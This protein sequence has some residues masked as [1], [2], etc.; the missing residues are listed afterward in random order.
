MKKDVIFCIE[1]GEKVS[2]SITSDRVEITIRGIKFS[3]VEL[4]AYCVKC[5]KEIYVPEVNDMNVV[6]REEAY[7]KAAGLISVSDIQNI[8]TKYNIGAGPL[9]KLLGFGEITINRYISGQLP[10]RDHS[11]K[12]LKLRFDRNMMKRILEEGKEKI[13]NVAYEKCNR[14]LEQLDYLYGQNKIDLVARYFLTKSGDITPLALQKLLYYA[15]SF[16]YALFKENLFEDDCQ[17]WAHGPVFPSVYYKYKEYGYDPIGC[18]IEA[19]ENDVNVFTNKE[20]CFLDA[21]I[22]CFGCYSGWILSNMTHNEI[23]WIEARGNLQPNDRSLTTINRKTINDYFENVV[24]KNEIVNPCD[25]SKYSVDMY[26]KIN[27]SNSIC[28]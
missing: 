22:S 6:S 10:S 7:R 14:T 4:S 13:S 9:A 2:Y 28:S 18:S 19:Y 8:L 21:I 17:A 26:K 25:I 15:Q 20:I 11:E 27:S 24:K 5:G 3:Y 23:P 1:C 16:Y 12:L